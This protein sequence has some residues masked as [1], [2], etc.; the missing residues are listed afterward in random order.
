VTIESG[1]TDAM[2]KKLLRTLAG[3]ATWPPP[4][5]LMRQ[6]GRYLPEYRDVRARAGSFIELCTTPA[7]AMEVTLQPLRRFGFDAAILFSDILMLPWALGQGLRYAEGEGPQLPPIRDAAGLR[8]LDAARVAGAIAPILE[9]VRG[10]R[11]EVGDATLLGFAGGPFTVACYMVE[12]RGSKEWDTVRRMAWTDP[13]LFSGLID[14]VTEQTIV[15]LSAQIDAGAEAVM[16]F[17]SW[18]GVLAPSL[19]RAHVIAPSVRIVAALGARHPG[20]PVIGFP[21]QA[22]TMLAEF[23]SAAGV[24]GIGVD[25]SA[26]LAMV[27]RDVPAGVAIQ[28]NLDPLALLAGGPAMMRETEAI[29]AAMQGRPFIFNLGHGIV[30]ETPPAHVAAL[31]AQVRAV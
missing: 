29:L 20:V 12:G 22:G 21:R 23:V 14:L 7:L 25:T 16:L 13:G 19:F 10:V 17:D 27:R 18:A 8:A 6:A 1:R 4:V 5:W 31:V 11:G 24:E 28:G 26:D 3:Q 9:T 15:Y 2:A 30:P